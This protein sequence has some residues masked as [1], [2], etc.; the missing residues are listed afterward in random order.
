MMPFSCKQLVCFDIDDT[1]YKEVWYLKSA[2]KEV[3]NFI[4][5]SGESD[6]AAVYEAMITLWSEGKSPFQEINTLLH[7]DV[8]IKE[9]LRIYREH[10]PYIH[11]DEGTENTLKALR[12]N[13]CIIGLITDGRSLTQR[14]KIEAL[15]LCDYIAECDI[16]I[17]EE[18][19]SEKPSALN[20]LYFMEKYPHAT[21][22]YVGDNLA[23]DFIAPNSL[24]WKTICLLDNGENIHQQDLSLSKEYQPDFF[25]K[26]IMETVELLNRC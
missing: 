6:S 14:N 17:S 1:L 10:K 23:K 26:D 2:F 4:A 25:I 13:D 12:K 5:K 7:I 9:C 8:P 16:V 22:T 19:G 21:F 11:L 15:G 20:Y 24:G 3:A 18:F